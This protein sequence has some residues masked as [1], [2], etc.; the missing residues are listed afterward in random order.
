MITS[1]KR[2]RIYCTN[3]QEIENYQYAVQ[4]PELYDL[5]HRKEIDTLEDGTVVLRSR[6]ELIDMG[7]YWHRPAEELIFLNHSE[8]TKLHMDAHHPMFGRT[9]DKS[10]RWEGDL[11]SDH[12]KR[13]RLRRQ[14]KSTT[15]SS[16]RC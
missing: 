8:H 3:F 13:L 5:H 15:C 1:E 14:K 12:A 6:K 16:K 10:P 11:A 9:G 2:L 7:L 4:S